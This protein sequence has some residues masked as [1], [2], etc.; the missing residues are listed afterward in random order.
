VVQTLAHSRRRHIR[1]QDLTRA[2]S[3][4]HV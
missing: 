4:R 1:P 3:A 2:P